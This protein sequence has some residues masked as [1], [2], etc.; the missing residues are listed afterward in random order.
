MLRGRADL[1]DFASAND[2]EESTVAWSEGRLRIHQGLENTGFGERHPRALL[3]RNLVFNVDLSRLNVGDD[4]RVVTRISAYAFN[5]RGGESSVVRLPARP[6][7]GR[8][9]PR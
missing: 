4:F 9:Q 3:K 5:Q 6:G 1:W 7:Q 8:R 2:R